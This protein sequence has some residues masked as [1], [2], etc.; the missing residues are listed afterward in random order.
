M[1]KVVVMVVAGLALNF[2][3]VAQNGIDS[4]NVPEVV[5]LN[6]R[7]KYPDVK[8]ETW[9]ISNGLYKAV[10]AENGKRLEAE[11]NS[12]G[13]YLQIE[14]LLRTKDVPALVLAGLNSTEFEQWEVDEASFVEKADS[15]AFYKLELKNGA[16]E[17]ELLF[18]VEGNAVNK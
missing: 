2:N 12:H 9:E 1:K 10:F 3:G 17:V 8:A 14:T 18:D 6:F 11:F 4:G 7:E 13:S 16:N 15:K 5:K